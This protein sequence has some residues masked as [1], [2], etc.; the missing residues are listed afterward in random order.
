MAWKRTR[1]NGTTFWED[2]VYLPKPDGGYLQRPV[3]ASTRAEVTRKKA[4]LLEK[5]DRKPR[6]KQGAKPTTMPQLGERFIDQH[7]PRVEHATQEYWLT[8]LRYRI[9]PYLYED[10]F[11]RARR[12][13]DLTVDDLDQWVSRLIKDG[14]TPRTINAALATLKT[15]LN[16]AIEWELVEVNRALAVKKLKEDQRR[17]RIY[18]PAEVF[19]MAGGAALRWTPAPD[20]GDGWERLDDVDL[21]TAT[22][23]RTM[24][25]VKAFTGVRL[26]E[27]L[28][29]RWEDLED[30]GR[31]LRVDR[32][33]KQVLNPETGRRTYVQAATKGKRQRSV[34][35][36]EPV[37]LALEWWRAYQGNPTT[38]WIF[39]NRLGG[40][41]QPTV[42]RGRYFKT[43]CRNAPATLTHEHVRRLQR[44]GRGWVLD[45]KVSDEPSGFPAATPHELRHTFASLMIAR[46]VTPL[47][48]S[49][50][51][52]HSDVVTT[53]RTYAHLFDRVEDDI[54]AKVNADLFQATPVTLSDEALPP[55]E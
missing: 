4:Q 30:E 29:L 19:R 49:S 14:H 47:R 35:V 46:G 27:L 12:I 37:R 53:M 48:L 33:V 9:A 55:A 39:P 2:K 16:K 44:V 43:A 54:V 1:A 40:T 3:R 18:A 51:L 24:I 8:A 26:G 41:L 20:L 5:R 45:E 10:E 25:V 36:L 28:G 21:P 50:W 15:M 6:A 38:G 52:G 17:P 23:D 32:Q 31:W 11:G 42:W 34:P 13:K 7:V 22:R